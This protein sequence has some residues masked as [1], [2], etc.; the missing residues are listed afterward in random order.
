MVIGRPI[1][2]NS[3]S[4]W[5]G[6]E[7]LGFSSTAAAFNFSSM[8]ITGIPSAI[9]AAAS[10][11]TLSN[12]LW[13]VFTTH[14]IGITADAGPSGYLFL[15]NPVDLKGMVITPNSLTVP[16]GVADQ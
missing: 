6:G 14:T 3:P 13:L 7:L 10:Y 5:Y 8:V 12:K 2:A 1:T 15:P 11:T 4:Q 16:G 9:A